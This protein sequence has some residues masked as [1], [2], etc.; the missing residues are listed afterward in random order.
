MAD[1]L[2]AVFTE[3]LLRQARDGDDNAARELAGYAHAY[4]SGEL[5]APMPEAVR[6]W[7]MDGCVAIAAGESA[8]KALL[9]RKRRGRPQSDGFEI[10]KE[11]HYSDLPRH[12]EPGGAYYEIGRQ[13]QKSPSAVERIYAHWRE[14]FEIHD[15]LNREEAPRWYPEK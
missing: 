15:E 5:A 10:A 11:V 9:T 13:F 3:H 7:L 8:D 1:E 2:S 4:L 14:G 12:K 6:I